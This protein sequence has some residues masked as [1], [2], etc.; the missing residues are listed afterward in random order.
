MSPR[1]ETRAQRG[2]RARTTLTHDGHEYAAG[3][4][5]PFG[6]WPDVPEL[7]AGDRF[8]YTGRVWRLL[9]VPQTPA[10]LFEARGAGG[11]AG[12]GLPEVHDYFATAGGCRW[13]IVPPSGDVVVLQAAPVANE[14]ARVRAYVSTGLVCP[15]EG[16]GE[17]D[18]GADCGGPQP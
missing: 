18:C 11:D 10:T 1:T 17:P 3:E 12:S 7:K 13:R 15:P 9:G 6:E 8:R 2:Y 16:C 5:I 4:Q 14:E